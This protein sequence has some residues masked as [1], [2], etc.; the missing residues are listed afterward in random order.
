MKKIEPGHIRIGIDRKVYFEYYKLKKPNFP[1][2][3]K[4]KEYLS[5]QMALLNHEE[6]MREY[7]ASKRLVEVNYTF[8]GELSKK[9][10]FN[11]KI[12]GIWEDVINNQKYKAEVTSKTATIIELIK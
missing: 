6:N 5:F 1:L 10:L 12:K 8:W 2:S 4:G 7:E 11:K 9:W 3:N